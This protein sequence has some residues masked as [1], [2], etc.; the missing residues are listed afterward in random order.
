MLHMC[1][2][3][4]DQMMYG[5]SDIVRDRFNCYFSFWA[6]SCLFTALTTQKIKIFKKWKKY[7]DISS[8]WICLPKIMIRWCTVPEIWCV[9]DV[10]ILHYEL[11]FALWDP[12]RPKNENFE[13]MKKMPGDIILL[14]MCGKNYDQMMYRSWDILR[15]RCNCYFSVWAIFWTYTTLTTRKIK[16]LK[17]WKNTW[18]YHHFTY[19]YQK[20]WSDDVPFLRYGASQM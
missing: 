20:L 5:S 15:N 3:N 1:I 13:K 17:K 10:I 4:Y 14:H 8:F 12:N 6:L 2:K 11:F 7:P 16:I 19:V 18:R 9:T